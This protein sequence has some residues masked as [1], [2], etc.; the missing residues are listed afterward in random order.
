M[1]QVTATITLD[2]TEIEER[3]VRSPGPGG[4][5]VN[6]TE[7]AV[8]LRFYARKSKALSNAVYLR[9]QK[10]AGRRMTSE[11]D[12]VIIANTFRTQEQNRKDARNRLIEMIRAA[13][14]VPKRRRATKPTKGSKER[15]LE[16]KRRRAGV[17][18]GRGGVGR[19]D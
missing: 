7:S 5:K 4:Q 11:G 3:F 8:Q 10:L 12:V 17:K 6:K 14:T 18:K 15:R 16:G 2:D 19:E 9:L 13:A 1:I